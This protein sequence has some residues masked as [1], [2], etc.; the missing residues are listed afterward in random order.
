M[1]G[2]STPLKNQTGGKSFFSFPGKRLGGQHKST[3]WNSLHFLLHWDSIWTASSRKASLDLNGFLGPG[4]GRLWQVLGAQGGRTHGN[5][6]IESD[7]FVCVFCVHFGARTS[8]TKRPQTGGPPVCGGP[9]SH[10]RVGR[11]FYYTDLVLPLSGELN[12]AVSSLQLNGIFRC[13]LERNSRTFLQ[14]IGF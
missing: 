13:V 2:H 10:F 4:L 3:G 5:L 11:M 6:N 7:S 14:V 9:L 8:P 12:P 1:G